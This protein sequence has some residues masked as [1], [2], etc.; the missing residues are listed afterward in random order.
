MATRKPGDRPIGIGL[1]GMG[2]VGG[3]VASTLLD[4]AESYSRRIG[5]PLQLRHV[6]VRD[7]TRARAAALPGGILTTDAARV[8]ADDETDIVVEVMGGEHPA[9]ECIT[10]ALERGR[11]VVTANKEV[12]AKHGPE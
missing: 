10:R 2:V 11:Y 5:M 7:Q 9:L 6:L 12:M 8:L 3:G 1:L 4:R